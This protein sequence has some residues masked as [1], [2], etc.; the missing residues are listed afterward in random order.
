[1]KKA[2]IALAVLLLLLAGTVC[3]SAVELTA[4]TIRAFD[5][6]ILTVFSEEGGSLTI[7]AWNGTLPMENIVTDLQIEAGTVEIL[8][9]GLSFGGE[10]VPPGKI[11]I[12][13]TLACWDRTVEQTEITALA[14]TPLTAVVC[15][16]PAAQ[17]FCPDSKNPLRI[18]IALSAAGTW[19]ISAAPKGRPEE[20]VWHDKGRSDGKFPVVLRWNG[21]RKAGVPCEPGEYV[22]TARSKACPDQVCA[23]EVTLLAEPLPVQEV[24]VT[25]SLMPDDFSDDAAVWTAL[26][27][28]IVIGDGVEGGGLLVMPEKG[29]HTGNIG[30]VDGRTSGIAVLEMTGDGWAKVGVWREEDGHYIE[31]WVKSERLHVIRPNDRYGAVVD[32][33]AQTMTVY[34]NGRRIG[35]MMISTG[36]TTAESRKADTHSGVYLTGTR[37]EAFSQDG[38][39]YNYPIRIDGPNLVHSTGYVPADGARDYDE[40]LALLGTKASHGC[41]RMDPRATEENGGINAWWVWTHLGHDTKIIVMPEE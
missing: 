40:E 4:G 23:A 25:G 21:M 19:E 35:T 11:R 26:T 28:P 24:T 16:L 38:H 32:K 33:Q 29:A 22:I 41:I 1:M 39:I 8:W 6:N 2:W 30:T 37:M 14:D 18:E 13:A 10:P 31:G 7:E 34:E 9:D 27:A 36:Y 20:T 12:R 15:C 5:R 3:A 17:R